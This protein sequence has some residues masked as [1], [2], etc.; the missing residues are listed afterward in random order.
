MGIKNSKLNG[1]RMDVLGLVSIQLPGP[2]LW[3]TEDIEDVK[4]KGV[5]FRGY[6]EGQE[7]KL[8]IAYLLVV[9][10][11]G[12]PEELNILSLDEDSAKDY[13]Q[14]LHR[15]IKKTLA[16]NGIELIKWMSSQLNDA[17]DFKGLVTAYIVKDQGKERQHIVLRIRVR[18]SNLVIMGC[19]DIAMKDQL[20]APIFDAFRSILILRPHGEE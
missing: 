6:G 11:T 8:D 17:E 7:Q 19:F 4:A 15:G 3:H 20:A 16:D 13:D 1:N 5:I 14:H 10:V 9:D 2:W 12:D 18:E